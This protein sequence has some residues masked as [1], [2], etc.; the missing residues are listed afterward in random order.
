M[1]YGPFALFNT[2]LKKTETDSD[3]MTIDEKTEELKIAIL[4]ACVHS[5]RANDLD[6]VEKGVGLLEKLGVLGLMHSNKTTE[7]TEPAEPSP[8]Q[9]NGTTEEQ[10]SLSPGGDSDSKDPEQNQE[11]DEL[12]SIEFDL[13]SAIEY[14][15]EKIQLTEDE[16]FWLEANEICK[17]GD[18]FHDGIRNRKDERIRPKAIGAAASRD[19]KIRYFSRGQRD[20]CYFRYSVL[21]YAKGIA[22]PW[23]GKV[24]RPHWFK[25][26]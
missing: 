12:D 21:L 5:S 26:D 24:D 11:D 9:E 4:D 16:L 3:S 13:D 8:R 15:K 25:T 20:N 18:P 22:D 6:K 19:G 10:P 2:N 1:L 7:N 17:A 23:R 14:T